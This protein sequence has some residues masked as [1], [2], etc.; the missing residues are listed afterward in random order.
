MKLE[1]KE[2]NIQLVPAATCFQFPW[3][4]P[5]GADPEILKRGATLC[6]PPWWAAEE[7]FRFQMV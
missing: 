1:K 3:H 5:A 7:N 4:M 6:R 2:L